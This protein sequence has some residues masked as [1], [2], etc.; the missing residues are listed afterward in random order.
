MPAKKTGKSKKHLRR[1]KSLKKVKPLAVDVYLTIPG[2]PAGNAGTGPNLG[3][4]ALSPSIANNL[5]R[6]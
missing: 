3:P 5:P 2:S 4:D 6:P 1:T